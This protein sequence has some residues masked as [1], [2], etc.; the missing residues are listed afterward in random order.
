MTLLVA[1]CGLVCHDA[2]S[3]KAVGRTS[4]HH[5]VS[6][7]AG[8]G[9]SLGHV[10]G[11]LFHALSGVLLLGGGVAVVGGALFALVFVVRLRRGP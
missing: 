11:S 5:A 1:W 3:S 4:P 2:A 8:V 6:P 7:L 10:A 9:G